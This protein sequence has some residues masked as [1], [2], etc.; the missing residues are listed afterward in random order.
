MK[1][2]EREFIPVILGGDITTY[3]LARSFHEEYHIR[4]IAISMQKNWLNSYSSIIENIIVP[5]MHKEEIFLKTLLDLGEKRGKDKKLILIACGD[6]YVRLIIEHRKELSPYYVIPYIEEDL[7]NRLVLKDSFY[8]ICDQ[9][10][11]PYPKTFVYDCK[12]KNEL[13]LPF[14]FP[15]IAKPASSA[16]Y[17]YAE[18]KGKK[19]VFKFETMDQLRAMLKEL[20]TSSYDYKFLIQDFIP[21]DDTYM[22]ILTCYCD[23]NSKVRFMSF[24]R[25]L[26]EDQGPMA[27]GNPVAIINEVKL[28]VMNKAKKMLEEV[29]YTGFANFD[30]KYDMRDHSYRYFEINTRLGRSNFYVTGSGFNAVKWIVDDLIYHKDFAE[31]PVI[32]DREN[33]YTVIPKSIIMKYVQDEKLKEQ[34][35]RLYR[36]GKVSNPIDYKGDTN[37]IHKLYAKYF[38]MK[39]KKRFEAYL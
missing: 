17:H 39:Q 27:I 37:L 15:V 21:G 6:W 4:S 31:E 5:N 11:V 22:N 2:E 3:S 28:D 7:M 33:L 9:T 34:V 25:T 24:G 38:M 36:E 23:R 12:E 29:G 14:G 35:E 10:G 32:A 20:E 18:F 16:Q 1:L 8:E 19:K 30:I 26:M 13:D